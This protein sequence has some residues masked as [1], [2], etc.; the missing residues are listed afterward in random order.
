MSMYQ[1]RSKL[2]DTLNKQLSNQQE[3]MYCLR[4]SLE[5]VRQ[6]MLVWLLLGE[7]LCSLAAELD[8]CCPD[9]SA[10]LQKECTCRW[11]LGPVDHMP[12]SCFEFGILKDGTALCTA[13]NSFQVWEHPMQQLLLSLLS[14][15]CKIRL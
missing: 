2:A 7:N 11:W 13:P 9:C 8:Y 1:W 15:L 6:V 14:P 12:N 10:C 5:T 4:P 3:L